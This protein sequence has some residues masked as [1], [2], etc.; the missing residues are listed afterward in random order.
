MKYKKVILKNGL[1]VLTVPM[2]ENETAM[3]LILVN[4]GAEFETKKESGLSHFLEHMCFKGTTRRPSAKI[5]SSEID[6]L[7]AA[8]NAFTDREMTGF[9]AKGDRKLLPRLFDIIAD[10]FLNSTFPAAEIEKEKGVIKGEIDMYEDEPRA[11]AAENFLKLL[12]GDTPGGRP[13]L[14]TK[15][16]VSGFSRQDFVNYHQKY[17]FP[18][19]TTVVVAGGVAEKEVSALARK[20]FGHLPAG[21]RPLP[22]PKLERKQRKPA[23]VFTKKK[24]DQSHIILGVRSFGLFDKREAV[25]DLLATV[26][27]S[28]MSS[29]LFLRLRDEMGAGYYVRASHNTLTDRGFLSVAT[30]TRSERVSEV[31]AAILSEMKRLR[32]EPVGEEELL[33]AKRFLVGHLKLSLEKSD[34]V[35][36]FLGPQEILRKTLETPAAI[37][38]KINKVSARDIQKLANEIFVGK[39]L[40]LS[41]V[42]PAKPNL[43]KIF[44]I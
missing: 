22:K 43:A 15:E 19:N 7:G 14:G 23:F 40:N 37:I 18:K 13:I 17:Y 32:D 41:L 38:K 1:R 5:I 27:G 3:V 28:G 33:K 9:Y 20:Y 12:Y 30:G 42:G 39:N 6:G 35:A 16:T 44:K 11:V 2:K 21:K 29:R 24:T 4:T 31:V 25:A 34:E 10:I 36:E 8:N 26:L